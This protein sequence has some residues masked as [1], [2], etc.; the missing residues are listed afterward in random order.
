M[1]LGVP[2]VTIH[3]LFAG[4]FAALIAQA[5]F[6]RDPVWMLAL[7][8]P[9][10]YCADRA[11]LPETLVAWGCALFAL[12]A[13]LFLIAMVVRS[14]GSGEVVMLLAAA[15]MLGL[16]SGTADARYIDLSR[17]SLHNP[18]LLGVQMESWLRVLTLR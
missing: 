18:P 3:L 4:A 7:A 10:L 13:G 9:L 12:G 8:L 16:A 15:A 14:I 5:A 17:S 2:M 6:R 11:G 1:L